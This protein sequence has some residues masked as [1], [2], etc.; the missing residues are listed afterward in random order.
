MVAMMSQTVWHQMCQRAG[1]TVWNRTGP[2]WAEKCPRQT[3]PCWH[4]TVRTAELQTHRP[5]HLP[6]GG[7]DPVEWQTARVQ[8][9]PASGHWSDAEQQFQ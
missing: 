2:G 4:C 6:T 8:I 7:C 9:R 3:S 5:P 1:Q